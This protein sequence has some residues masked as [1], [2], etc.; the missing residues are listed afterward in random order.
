MEVGLECWLLAR[1]VGRVSDMAN[2]SSGQQA[3]QSAQQGG[4]QT[5]TR[6]KPR[7]L[8]FCSFCPI[9]SFNYFV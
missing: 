4:R 6:T 7:G 9:S 5:A 2:H 3:G 1:C 8:C